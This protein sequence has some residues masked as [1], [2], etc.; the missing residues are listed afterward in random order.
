MNLFVFGIGYSA[1]HFV[2]ETTGFSEIAGTVRSADKAAAL[3]REGIDALVFDGEAEAD[4]AIAAELARA[5]LC[6]VSTQP[7]AMGDPVLGA[8]ARAIE[9]APRLK[10][11]VYLSTIGVFGD[12]GGAWIDESTVPVPQN[13]RGRQRLVVEGDWLAVG[14]KT[15]KTVSVLRLAG[16]YGPGRNALDDLA[17][18]EARRIFKPGQ[19][20]NRIHVTDIGRAIDGAFAHG[21][22]SAAWNV[23]DDEPAP[24]ADV[25]AYAARLMGI[26]PPPL[27]P[28]AEADL[29]PMARSFYGANRRV[30]NG[31][32]KSRLG[33]TLAYPTF[34]EGLATLWSAGEGRTASPT[35]GALS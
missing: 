16:I 5:D 22:D 15:G 12:H 6:L 10:S 8:F 33:V 31:A 4:P 18:G 28:F 19:V 35:G 32:I 21:R 27:V 20:F 9:R 1:G 23:A 7:G 30:A 17:N 11:I 29:S 13:D 34:R 25:V 14:A 3:R 2:R 24:A 26:D